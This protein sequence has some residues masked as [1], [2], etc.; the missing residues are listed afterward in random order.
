MRI[1]FMNRMLGTFEFLRREIS[2]R[3]L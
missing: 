2:A 3:K 1:Y